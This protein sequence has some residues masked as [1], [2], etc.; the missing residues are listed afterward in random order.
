MTSLSPDLMSVCDLAGHFS[1]TKS[2]GMSHI[3]LNERVYGPPW[4]SFWPCWQRSELAGKKGGAASEGDQLR[5][6]YITRSDVSNCSYLTQLPKR[7]LLSPVLVVFHTQALYLLHSSTLDHLHQP[8]STNTPHH[9][10]MSAQEGRQSPPPEAQSGRQQQDAPGSGKGADKIDS[11]DKKGEMKDQLAGLSS[12]PKGVLD[13]A[14]DA[15][16]SKTTEPGA[17]SS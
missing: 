3:Q 1:R 6:V 14:V 13:D 17:K 10:T 16:F 5:F 2:C 9:I 4:F 7:L 12:N 11:G 15:K 8:N